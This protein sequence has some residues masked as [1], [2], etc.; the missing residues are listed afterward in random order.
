MLALA[1][2]NI[3]KLSR[4]ITMST[5]VKIT[6]AVF[7]CQTDEDI[8]F[9][10]L[11]NVTGIENIVTNNSSLHISISN[12]QKDQALIDL[13]AICDIWHASLKQTG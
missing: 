7:K 10:R 6:G 3:S 13:I 2:N 5:E 8:F 1:L 12:E 9:Q 11:S 4:D